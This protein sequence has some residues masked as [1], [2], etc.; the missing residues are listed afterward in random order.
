MPTILEKT[1]NLF[2]S[3]K[4]KSP[5]IITDN[6]TLEELLFLHLMTIIRMVF[7]PS[8][9]AKNISKWWNKPPLPLCIQ[10]YPSLNPQRT[11][12]HLHHHQRSLP[13]PTLP[14][15]QNAISRNNLLE[16]LLCSSKHKKHKSYLK[17]TVSI[18]ENPDIGQRTVHNSKE[19]SNRYVL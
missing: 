1:K 14:T 11:H 9:P 6:Y 4:R 10:L 15:S 16:R 18:V 19:K 7:S 5:H 3:L 2:I 13:C 8:I 17:A 12:W